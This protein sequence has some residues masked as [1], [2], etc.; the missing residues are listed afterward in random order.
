MP[1]RARFARADHPPSRIQHPTL[2]QVIAYFKY[3]TTKRYNQLQAQGGTVRWHTNYYERHLT[4]CRT[5]LA[6]RA[7]ILSNPERWQEI[8]ITP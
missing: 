8:R 2:G 1:L 6:A 7:Y 4:N 3:Q 5:L